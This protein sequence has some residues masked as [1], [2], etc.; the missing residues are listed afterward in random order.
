M[1]K[2]KPIALLVSILG[3]LFI[4][5]QKSRAQP[6]I[7]AIGDSLTFGHGVSDKDSWPKKLEAKLAKDG[8]KS[9][10]IVNAGVSGATTASGMQTLRFH[11]RRKKPDL[12]I[13]ALGANDGLRGI[14]PQATEQNMRQFVKEAKKHG[15]QILLLGMKAPPNYGEKYPKKFEASFKKVADEEKLSFLP[16]FLEGVAGEKDLNQADGIHPNE[17]GYEVITETIYKKV[18]PLL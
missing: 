14:R 1:H 13:Y 17:K 11:L 18:K 9:I 12:I 16:F 6:I 7:L 3:L 15:I 10:K 4:C 5:P 2:Y 8:F